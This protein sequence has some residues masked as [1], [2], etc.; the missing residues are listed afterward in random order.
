MIDSEVHPTP[1]RPPN[2]RHQRRTSD[3][4][5]LLFDRRTKT[6]PGVSEVLTKWTICRNIDRV[7]NGS[8]CHFCCPGMQV[9]SFLPKDFFAFRFCWIKTQKTS[10]TLTI[11]NWFIAAQSQCKTHCR[12]QAKLCFILLICYLQLQHIPD[13]DAERRQRPRYRRRWSRSHRAHAARLMECFLPSKGS[14]AKRRGSKQEEEQSGGD[15]LTRQNNK[16]MEGGCFFF[17]LVPAP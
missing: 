17:Y 10:S 2:K 1:G 5:L 4:Y 9:K 6:H 8:V 14:R 13:L 7:S 11:N 15:L 3:I 12:T 16:Y